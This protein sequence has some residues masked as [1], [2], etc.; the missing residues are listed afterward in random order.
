MKDEEIKLEYQVQ[1]SNRFDALVTSN[2]DAGEVDIN[3][4]WENIRDIK[5]AA[6]ESI[7]YYDLMKMKPWLDDDFLHVV[8]RRK[9]AKLK[10]LQDPTNLIGIIITLKDI[11]PV[12]HLD[13]KRQIF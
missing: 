12:A 7:G 8:E 1:I 2:D 11:R 9:Q 4:T 13:T 5:V 10:F 6:E 3:D